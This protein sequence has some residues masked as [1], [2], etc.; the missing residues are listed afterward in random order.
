MPGGN[1]R[2]NGVCANVGMLPIL[3]RTAFAAKE[4]FSS[5]LY[6]HLHKKLDP[7]V[8]EVG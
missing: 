8:N 5:R 7:I 2:I 3:S 1:G 4:H 6:H